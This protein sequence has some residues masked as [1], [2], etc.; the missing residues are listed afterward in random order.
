MCRQLGQAEGTNGRE[1]D[2]EVELGESAA[3]IGCAGN[4]LRK[5]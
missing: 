2:S 4:A 1:L 3:V 5:G